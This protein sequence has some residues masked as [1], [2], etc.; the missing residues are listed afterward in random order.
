MYFFFF[1]FLNSVMFHFVLCHMLFVFLIWLEN[2]YNTITRKRTTS[3]TS[4]FRSS[5]WRIFRPAGS[6]FRYPLDLLILYSHD[7]KRDQL[8]MVGGQIL[9]SQYRSQ[10]QW[11]RPALCSPVAIVVQGLDPP[12]TTGTAS[13]LPGAGRVYLKATQPALSCS[14]HRVM[15]VF[16][17]LTASPIS[18]S[19]L[20]RTPGSD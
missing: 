13:L 19:P 11:C 18:S 5:S 20:L 12:P 15:R 3:S 16:Q 7:D 10:K 14:R 2:K 8:I 6:T 4:L 9:P 17:E 1:F